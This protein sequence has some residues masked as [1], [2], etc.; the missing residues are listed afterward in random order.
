MNKL[1]GITDTLVLNPQ[2]GVSVYV[3]SRD[4]SGKGIMDYFELS[5]NFPPLL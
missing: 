3:Y 5:D 1:Y 4:G 2:K